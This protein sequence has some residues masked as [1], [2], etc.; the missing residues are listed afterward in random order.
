[1]LSSPNHA[2]I[3]PA[4][5]QKMTIAHTAHWLPFGAD[6]SAQITKCDVTGYFVP[7]V[8][9]GGSATSTFRGRNLC[10]A[11]TDLAGFQWYVN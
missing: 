4:Y 3:R 9:E 6:S 2:R 11:E 5:P 1:M 8:N 7:S 10:G